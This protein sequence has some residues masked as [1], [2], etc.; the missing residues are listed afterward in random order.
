MKRCGFLALL[1]ALAAVSIQAH[2]ARSFTIAQTAP[3]ALG[4]VDMGATQ[5]LTYTVTNNASGT[6]AGERVVQRACRTIGLKAGR[7]F[8]IA[9]RVGPETEIA[10]LVRQAA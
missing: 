9:N 2:A 5:V 3:A 7:A 6:N 4:E 10:A 1:I 8:P